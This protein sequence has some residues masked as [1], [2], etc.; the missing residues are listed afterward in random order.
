[1][2]FRR[3][4]PNRVV[5]LLGVPLAAM[6]AAACGGGSTEATPTADV[7]VDTAT[8]VPPSSPQAQATA[9]PVVTATAVPTAAAASS[10]T[11]APSPTE[12][13]AATPTDTPAPTATATNTPVVIG[14]LQ[15]ASSGFAAGAPIPAVFT[16]DGANV[17]PTLSWADAPGGTV[18]FA[19]V[20]ADP[21]A[22]QGTFIHWLASDIPG[23]TTQLAQNWAASGAAGVVFGRN[24]FLQQN[25]LGPCPPAIDDPHRYEFRV[26]ALDAVLNLGA[27]YSLAQLTAA[28]DGRILAQGILTGTYDR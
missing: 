19:V 23:A 15:V 14:N 16:C 27:G 9:T 2:H 12:T 17:S 13:V 6:V 8:A 22:P 1:M 5:I 25:Y 20:L 11:A 26:F 18:S 28:M 24:D 7:A 3:G 4:V 21:D 10:P